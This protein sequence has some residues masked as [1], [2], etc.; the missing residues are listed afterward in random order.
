[1]REKT[2]VD[3][4]DF[5]PFDLDHMHMTNERPSISSVKSDRRG[6]IIHSVNDRAKRGCLMT[7]Q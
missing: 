6:L 1:M 5:C 2:H 3:L 4:V 7:L